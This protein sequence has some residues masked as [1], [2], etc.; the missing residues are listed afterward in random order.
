MT[1]TDHQWMS[2]V[3]VTP[4]NWDAAFGKCPFCH[5]ADVR[6][7]NEMHTLIG[8]GDGTRK[9]DPNHWHSDGRCRACGKTF[10][11]E[12]C[13]GNVWFTQGERDG[14]VIAGVASCFESYVYPC[15]CGGQIKR[16][17]TNLG[18]TG[19]PSALG[20][21]WDEQEEKWIKDYRTFYQ[22][23]SCGYDEEVQSDYPRFLRK[24]PQ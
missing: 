5:S 10:M 22:C 6:F 24:H 18:G 4:L 21:R 23:A 19:H 13:C 2:H 20:T 14:V 11:Q 1:P 9:G 17:Y 12:T 3:T 15:T 8:G 16:R 7:T